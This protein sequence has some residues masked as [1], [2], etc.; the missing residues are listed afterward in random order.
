M[1]RE[2]ALVQAEKDGIPFP[3]EQTAS[4]EKLKEPLP[5]ERKAYDLCKQGVWTQKEIAGMIVREH[6]ILIDQP[7]VSRAKSKV[8]KWLGN[9]SS[10]QSSSRRAPKKHTVD[11]QKLQ[12]VIPDSGAPIAEQ[13]PSPLRDRMAK[14]REKKD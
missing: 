5:W 13:H 8:E 14:Q 10:R 3:P 2:D 11:P 4:Q 12:H 1:S 9:S 6:G 7:R